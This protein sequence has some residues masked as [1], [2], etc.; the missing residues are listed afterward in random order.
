MTVT[1]TLLGIHVEW[2]EEKASTNLEKHGVSFETACEVF[3]D[4]FVATIDEQHVDGEFR[5]VILGLT[6]HWQ[7]LSVVHT[8]R[9]GETVRLISAR[10]ATRTERN[11]YE[12]Q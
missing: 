3:F 10:R 12:T 6:T 11:H 8:L 1:Y 9:I 5:E 2:D 4:P 7:L